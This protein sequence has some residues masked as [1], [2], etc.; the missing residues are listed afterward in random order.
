MAYKRS[1]PEAFD[2]YSKVRVV[3][4]FNNKTGIKKSLSLNYDY[5]SDYYD[6]DVK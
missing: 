5:E 2:N 1:E 6:V 3:L 4:Y